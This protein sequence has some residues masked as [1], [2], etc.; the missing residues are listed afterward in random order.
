MFEV[1]Q[2]ERAFAVINGPEMKLNS[3][4]SQEAT[5]T[6]TAL[7]FPLP[8]P[9]FPLDNVHTL[10]GKAFYVARSDGPHDC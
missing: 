8:P 7:S 4:R 10:P 1:V 6:T 2:V 5:L 3:Q 9:S